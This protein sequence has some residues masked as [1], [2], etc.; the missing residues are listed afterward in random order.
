MFFLL[1]AVALSLA[2]AADIYDVSMTEK[3]LKA[4]VAVEGYTWLV[5]EKPSAKALY[6]RDTL[7]LAMTAAPSAVAY[8]LGNAPLA[9]GCLAGPAVLAVKHVIGGRKWKKLLA[10]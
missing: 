6:L 1:L 4:G 9:F 5:G 10:V 7:V 2:V 3:G 8:F